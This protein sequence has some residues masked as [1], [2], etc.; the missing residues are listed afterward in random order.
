MYNINN[1]GYLHHGRSD[2]ALCYFYEAVRTADCCVRRS[3]CV[4][5][6]AFLYNDMNARYVLGIS[7]LALLFLVFGDNISGID[8]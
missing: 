2:I 3:L 1:G 7:F 4:P 6:D 5:L 8:C